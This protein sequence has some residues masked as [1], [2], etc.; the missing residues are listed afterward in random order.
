MLTGE[1]VHFYGFLQVLL[2]GKDLRVSM[3]DA[4]DLLSEA[5][6]LVKDLDRAR[7]GFNRQLVKLDSKGRVTI[8]STFRTRLGWSEGSLREVVLDEEHRAVI[9]K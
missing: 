4:E 5:M 3:D 6:K 8:P 7:R 2:E 9:V 1:R